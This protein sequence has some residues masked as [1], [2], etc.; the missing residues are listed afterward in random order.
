MRLLRAYGIELILVGALGLAVLFFGYL[1][2]GLLPN[3]RVDDEFSG[4]RAIANIRSQLSF[5][6]RGA[7]TRNSLQTGEWLVQ[8]LTGLGWDVIIQEFDIGGGV[9]GRNYVAVR[10]PEAPAAPVG[11]LA[12]H[13]DTR[14]AADADPTELY[15]T[16]PTPGANSGAS[17]VATLLELA[18]TLDVEK[19]GHTICLVFFDAEENEG[20]P[21]WEGQMGSR[22][23]ID[24]LEQDALRCAGPNFAVALDRVGSV[25]QQFFF[26]Q[27]SSPGLSTAL[28]Q[29][30]DEAGFGD[31][32]IPEVKANEANA[33]TAFAAAGF[34]T[35]LI[36]DVDYP[37]RYT[38]SDTLDKLSAE[39]LERVGRT[40]E[41][42][43]EGGARFNP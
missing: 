10:S 22:V 13:Y 16:R 3:N 42:W 24:E 39:S 2:L 8:Q 38:M 7:G 20:I 36:A 23:F 14:L 25:D 19:S 15:R 43:L 37:Y 29:A 17:G 35:A 21:G 32:F 5:G 6:A 11:I 31:V 9:L 34:P 18:R 27:S 4:E 41:A 1:A 28:W 12:T 26:Q 30:A 33:H 40:L